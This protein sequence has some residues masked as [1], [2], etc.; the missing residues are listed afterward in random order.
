M[1]TVSLVRKITIWF[2]CGSLVVSCQQ[3]DEQN[4][5]L[6]S[7]I[8]IKKEV[9]ANFNLAEVK[10]VSNV[11]NLKKL[12]TEENWQAVDA[13]IKLGD[14]AWPALDAGAT[15]QSFRSRQ[16]TM[17]S[18]GA[19]GTDKS[20]HILV[21]GLDDKHIN[22][23]LAAA[24][25]LSVNTPPDA[26]MALARKLRTCEE[27]NICSLLILGLGNVP[28]EL[29]VNSILE[30]SQNNHELTGVAQLA[31]SKLERKTSI[32]AQL[33][34]FSSSNPSARYQALIDLIYIADK[35]YASYA[36]ALLR[37][38]A[39]AISIGTPY[40]EEHRRV[41]DQ[42]VDTLIELLQL[43]PSFITSA[44]MI[45][46]GQQINEIIQLTN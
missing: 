21:E 25:Q 2:L 39:V 18:A 36:I 42:S 28:G 46:N 11:A 32:D 29:S 24:G 33:M 45:Y 7:D 19:I 10:E 27:H 37:D 30:F 15:M 44:E 26:Q 35:N 38:K 1:I 3:V 34:L 13:A 17:A 4:Q 40:D 41:C 16:I 22:V 5:T 20:I 43:T 12:L 8:F 14:N 31:L 23:R 9:S 6:E